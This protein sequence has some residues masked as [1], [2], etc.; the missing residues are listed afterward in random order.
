MKNTTSNY[1]NY[2][3]QLEKIQLQSESR[4]SKGP[5]SL[6]LQTQQIKLLQKLYQAIQQSHPTEAISRLPPN[7]SNMTTAQTWSV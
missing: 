3:Q 6:K 4:N 5:T 1:T 2:T 7:S